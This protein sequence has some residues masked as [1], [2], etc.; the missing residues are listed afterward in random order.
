MLPLFVSIF[1]SPRTTLL[2]P[3]H[4]RRDA[5]GEPRECSLRRFWYRSDDHRLQPNQFSGATDDGAQ[6][7]LTSLNCILEPIFMLSFGCSNYLSKDATYSSKFHNFTVAMRDGF[8]QHG[9][10]VTF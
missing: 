4:I 8:K 5:D 1:L 3:A 9:M 2:T 10:A 6:L 7:A